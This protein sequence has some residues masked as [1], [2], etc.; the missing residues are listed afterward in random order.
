MRKSAP[1]KS[2]RRLLRSALSLVAVA[3][4]AVGGCALPHHERSPVDSAGPASLAGADDEVRNIILMIADGAGVGLWTAAKY[5][6]DQLAVTRMP[7]TGLVDTRSAMHKVTDSAAGATVYATGERA[8]NRTISVGPAT[9]CPLPRS[10][11]AEDRA[12]PPGCKP[13][14]TWFEVARDKGRATGIVTTT[15]VADATPAAFVAH[16]PNRYWSGA[17]A[18]QFADFGLDVLLGGGE[19]DFAAG[20]RSD[21][22]DVLGEMCRRSRCLASA[23]ELRRY[24]ADDRALV[25]LFAP[26]DMDE[27]APRPAGLPDMVEAAL[28]KLERDPDGFVAMFETEATDNATHANAPLERVTADMLEFDRAVAVALDFAGRRPGTLV[29]VTADHETGGFSLVEAE[30]DFELVYANRGHSAAMVPLFAIGPQSERFGGLRENHEIGQTLK[31]IV[32][33]W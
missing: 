23:D 13:L 10:G 29:I 15:F 19:R 24:R 22:R 28:E 12:W 26:S 11:D 9:A 21:G 8:M 4:Y 33:A 27:F 16:S 7:V 31:E 3:T 1:E 20:T 30:N 6:D 18:L 14:I 5:A 25:G 32:H 2:A 17:L